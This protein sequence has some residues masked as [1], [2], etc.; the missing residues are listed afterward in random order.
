M[1]RKSPGIQFLTPRF[2]SMY[3]RVGPNPKL[4]EQALARYLDVLPARRS[5]HVVVAVV[6]HDLTQRAPLATLQRLNLRTCRPACKDRSKLD[7][8][9]NAKRPNVPN[10]NY[11]IHKFEN[12]KVRILRSARNSSEIPGQ[13]SAW[14]TGSTLNMPLRVLIHQ[15]DCCYRI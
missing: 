6:H 2:L 8:A 9:V 1:V 5:Q 11:M 14:V 15:E 10:G 12:S 3:E 7:Y 13:I 4:R